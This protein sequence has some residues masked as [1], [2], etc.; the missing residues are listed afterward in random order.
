MTTYKIISDNSTLGNK[1]A[2]VSESDLVGLNVEALLAGEQ[3]ETVTASGR[4]QDKKEQD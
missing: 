2:L 3:L 1:G 4:K